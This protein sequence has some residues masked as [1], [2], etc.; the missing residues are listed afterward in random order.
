LTGGHAQLRCALLELHG[1]AS[2]VSSSIDEAAS[3]VHVAVVVYADL[4]NDIDWVT[5]TDPTVSDIH[6][7]A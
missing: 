4:A 3:N 5:V 7:C 6:T 1:V 2:S